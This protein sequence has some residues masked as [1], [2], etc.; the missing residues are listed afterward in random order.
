MSLL[1]LRR[2]TITT[3]ASKTSWQEDGPPGTR[4]LV[5]RSFALGSQQRDAIL[6]PR[7]APEPRT[8]ARQTVRPG[9]AHCGE[10]AGRYLPAAAAGWLAARLTARR[11]G[12]ECSTRPPKLVSSSEPWSRPSVPGTPMLAGAAATRALSRP[13]PIMPNARRRS[14][15]NRQA[16]VAPPGSMFLRSAR[17]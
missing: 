9:S 2:P 1:G 8:P 17:A 5:T 12:G 14:S 7:A 3:Q 4:R 10:H 13:N 15:C 16:L 6:I 11:P